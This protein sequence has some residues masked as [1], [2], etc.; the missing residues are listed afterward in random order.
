MSVC[1]CLIDYHLKGSTRTP[2]SKKNIHKK[3]SK[4]ILSKKKKDTQTAK[5]T[6]DSFFFWVGI[7]F[8]FTSGDFCWGDGEAT[9][10]VGTRRT[11]NPKKHENIDVFWSRQKQGGCGFI[12]P[13][14]KKLITKNRWGKTQHSTFK[15]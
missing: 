9:V 4:K 12:C 1:V 11:P 8:V 5:Y 2:F 10:W 15:F 6:T 3:E 7:F 13:A 14:Q